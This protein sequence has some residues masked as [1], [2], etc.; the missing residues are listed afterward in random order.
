MCTRRHGEECLGKQYIINRAA[1][2]ALSQSMSVSV[3][4]SIN[5]S[6]REYST[7]NIA[8]CDL[9]RYYKQFCILGP[10]APQSY[11]TLRRIWKGQNC[12]FVRNDQ[13]SR[14]VC[15]FESNP[16]LLQAY[17]FSNW[18]EES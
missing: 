17:T 11:S 13:S 5:Q 10:S 2:P 12:L 1:L 16:S 9:T 14:I 8:N 4:V 3:P 18:N 6:R 15:T 7:I